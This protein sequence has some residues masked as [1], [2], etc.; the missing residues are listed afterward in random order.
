MMCLLALAC[1]TMMTSCN[2]EKDEDTNN[3]EL[4]IG[5]WRMSFQSYSANYS[6][7]DYYYFLTDGEIYDSSALD[8]TFT[9]D[10]VVFIPA[11]GLKGNYTLDGEN[12]AIY[13]EGERF[14]GVIKKL[15][16][17]ELVFD[18]FDEDKYFHLVCDRIN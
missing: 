6:N 10:N 12:I 14:S 5:K 4:L 16:S 15:T 3:S 18:L 13:A 8:V 2:K 7:Q 9:R 1:T 11:I 17:K